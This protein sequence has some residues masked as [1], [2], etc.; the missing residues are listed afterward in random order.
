MAEVEKGFLR[1][2][3]DQELVDPK[4]RI[5]L[6]NVL[7]TTSAMG[8][9]LEPSVERESGLIFLNLTSDTLV[10]TQTNAKTSAVAL[11]RVLFSF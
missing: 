4:T 9:S 1:T 11:G 3:F 7:N 8:L 6:V 10:V 5:N 2:A